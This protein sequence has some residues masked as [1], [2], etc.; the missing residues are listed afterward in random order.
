MERLRS[1]ATRRKAGLAAAVVMAG[2]LAGGVLL[3]PGTAFAAAPTSTTISVT[4]SGGNGSGAALE[5]N[6]HV[7]SAPGAPAPTGA[8]EVT[9]FGHSYGCTADLTA[10][11]S[12]DESWGS[13]SLGWVPSGTYGIEASYSPNGVFTGSASTYDWV[14]VSGSSSVGTG[15]GG[16]QHGH[17]STSLS[18]PASVRNGGTGTCSLTVTNDSWNGSGSSTDVTAKISLP[19]Q[20]TAGSCAANGAGQPWGHPWGW[21]GGCSISGNTASANL[22]SLGWGD[23]QTLSVTFTAHS[24]GGWYWNHRH[25]VEVTGSASTSGN[26]NWGWGQTSTS[27]AWVTI[28][29]Y[30][31]A[32]PWW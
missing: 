25:G 5:A 13:C 32:H 11:A 10:P 4:Q 28:T 3:T 15:P 21:N 20:L 7:T 22:G 31:G 23:S 2:G 17:L 26:W 19:K 9:A 1:L 18:C 29:P 16:N 27:S 8:V 6:V 24:F 12:G 14:T 30:W